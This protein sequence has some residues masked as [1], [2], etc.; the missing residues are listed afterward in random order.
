MKTELER[1]M[2]NPEER[3]GNLLGVARE[4]SHRLSSR[5]FIDD[6]NIP[7]VSLP[8]GGE[9][10]LNSILS[11][12][13]WAKEGFSL[14]YKSED[15]HVGDIKGFL[16]VTTP[17]TL[18]DFSDEFDR[19]GLKLKKYVVKEGGRVTV[20]KCT[21]ITIDL[22]SGLGQYS[23]QSGTSSWP[24]EPSF[25]TVWH[26]L[27]EIDTATKEMLLDKSLQIKID[28]QIRAAH[29]FTA[30]SGLLKIVA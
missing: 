24:Y 19:L 10:G 16:K 12:M 3:Y 25:E 13:T 22:L 8:L 6:Q 15:L 23:D 9:D 11:F 30:C 27:E 7:L 28:S 29:F 17:K 18:V 14:D 20:Y 2:S 26:L 5:L 1:V 21:R 4:A